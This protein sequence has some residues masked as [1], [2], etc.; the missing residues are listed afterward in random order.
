MHRAVR[1]PMVCGKTQSVDEAP[2]PVRPPTRTGERVG[3]IVG[4][5]L[6][7]T[8]SAVALVIELGKPEMLINREGESITPSVVLFQGDDPLVGTM[9]KRSAATAPLDVV[10]FVKRQMGD[11]SWC[12]ETTTGTK[13]RPEEISGIILK[14][15]K[16]DAELTLGE[17]AVTDAVITVPA[18]FDDAQRRATKDAGRIAGLNVRRVLN[19]PTAAALAY[20]LDSQVGGT[21]L[22][23]DLGGGTFDVTVMRVG[24]GEFDVL[25][26]DGDRNL[27]G[28]DWDNLLMRWLNDA[29]MKEGGPDLFD[30]DD[31]DADVREADLR[32][33][34]EMAKRSLS[35][36]AKANV[37]L[38]AGGVS[39]VISITRQTFEDLTSGLLNRSRDLMLSVLEEA[40]LS[41][42]QID[43]LLLVGGSTRMPMVRTMVEGLAGQ[44]S[45]RTINPDEVVALGAAILGHIVESEDAGGDLLP[46]L[47][48]GG[49]PVVIKDVTSQSLGVIT[50][51][52][53]RRSDINSIIIK[54]NSKIPCKRDNTYTTVRDGQGQI[55][56]EVTQGD[57]EDPQYCTIVGRQTMSI[58]PYPE[59]A[60]LR[61]VFAYDIDQT[62]HIEVFDLT[63][64]KSLGSFEVDN[65]ANLSD[66]DVDAAVQKIKDLEVS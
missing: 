59:G 39:K 14:R 11:A 48:P 51:A 42:S 33:K 19:E 29:F 62:I 9:A 58:P 40:D 37:A 17:G 36:V 22:V 34:A 24:D 57:D 27:G 26:T 44:E 1:Q 16:E 65:S 2:N 55:E 12:F 30:D 56:V 45:I 3:R 46:D 25:R 64:D 28:F 21:L 60:P 18:Y 49:K 20:G 41:W 5:D 13:Y 47:M 43:K 23:Y 38:T 66:A 6:G 15:L 63:A 53:D 52:P 8:F 35:M 61:V 31:E 54:A 7:T 32:E 50:L 10:Q 4:I